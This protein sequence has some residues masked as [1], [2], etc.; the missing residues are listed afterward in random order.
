MVGDGP[1]RENIVNGDDVRVKFDSDHIFFSGFVD[2]IDPLV[3]ASS[4]VLVPSKDDG[5]PLVVLHSQVHG[6]PV[7]GTR[8]GAIPLMIEDGFNGYLVDA[9]DIGAFREKIC[10]LQANSDELKRLGQNAFTNVREK[11]AQNLMIQKYQ[12]LLKSP[13]LQGS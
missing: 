1:E 7:I 5:Q 8:V 6:K 10:F 13:D 4:V 11:F 2:R 9:G 3:S 12:K